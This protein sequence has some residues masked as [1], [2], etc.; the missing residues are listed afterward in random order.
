[1][2]DIRKR[3][4]KKGTTYQ[5]RYKDPSSDSGYSYEA[6]DTLL[7]ARAFREDTKPK[8]GRRNGSSVLT[9]EQAIDKWLEVCEG[10]GR[11][12]RDPVSAATME[13]Y[14]YR[15][16][17]MKSY[18]WD[19]D[20]FQ[21]TKADIKKFRSWLKR[22]YS[23]DKA[24][25]VLS[26]FHSVVLEMHD[27][28]IIKEDPAAGITV[29]IDSRYKEPTRIPSVADLQTLLK[30]ADRLANSKNKQIADSFERY[31]AMI[32]LAADSG[33]RPQEYLV[34]PLLGLEG[35]GVRIVQALDRSNEIGPP[36]TKAGRR[37]ILT[38]GQSVEMARHYAYKSGAE[39]PD[40]FVFPA[41][42]SGS[43]QSYR[44]FLRDGWH[45]LMDEAGFTEEVKENG[46]AKLVRRYTPY[47]LRH[48][49]ASMLIENNK[50][51]KYIQTV[52]G[53]EDIEMTFNVYGHLIRK[54]E[55]E[56]EE[57]QGGVLRYLAP[58]SC[59]EFVSTDA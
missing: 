22:E 16:R 21:L 35:N 2:A 42:N 46:K 43:Y 12:D 38:G 14:R 47:A 11:N 53:H 24:Q 6:F 39:A 10:E 50:S 19:C 37:F 25:K 32:Y 29:T 13:Q 7:E 27:Q 41:R 40:D 48:F 31:R 57:A 44:R 5:V 55:T 34:L 33:M 51:A 58:S 52:M 8:K 30:T 1:M 9:V 59:G 36:K 3:T 28:E 54:R 17:V 23:L 18:A 56:L 20:L 4:G 45:R 26:S 49:F 15:A